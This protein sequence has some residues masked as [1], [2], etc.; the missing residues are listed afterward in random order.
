MEFD[1]FLA[2][3][4]RQPFVRGAN[5]LVAAELARQIIDAR[6]ALARHA[7]IEKIGAPMDFGFDVGAE[8]ERGFETV[9]ADIAPGT[10]DIG[11]DFDHDPLL[12]AASVRFRSAGAAFRR[13]RP[14]ALE[15]QARLTCLVK[16]FS[17]GRWI[18]ALDRE[19][20]AEE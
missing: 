12:H 18:V 16:R 14:N 5:A 13:P 19:P 9:L 17:R 1:A 8:R 4:P 3:E 7:R 10:H 6:H 20:R 2:A 15:Y 11:N